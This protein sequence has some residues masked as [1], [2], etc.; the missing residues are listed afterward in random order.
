[1]EPGH[2]AKQS[3]ARRERERGVESRFKGTA[4]GH[5]GAEAMGGKL[6]AAGAG[7]GV[8]WVEGCVDKCMM[9]MHVS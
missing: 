4:R 3:K 2:I 7:K 1:M 6:D 5:D 9:S 8:R